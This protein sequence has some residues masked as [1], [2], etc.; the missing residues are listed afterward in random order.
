MVFPFL[1][2]YVGPALPTRFTPM[3]DQS[4]RQKCRNFIVVCLPI[5][6]FDSY[7]LQCTN[8]CVSPSS[9]HL[10]KRWC[11]NQNYGSLSKLARRNDSLTC[12]DLWWRAKKWKKAMG[13]IYWSSAS[14][15]RTPWWWVNGEV[16]VSNPGVRV[17][18]TNITV[19][20]DLFGRFF[21]CLEWSRYH[22]S[23]LKEFIN[24]DIFKI[25]KYIS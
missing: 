12:N 14:T 25:L 10:A 8:W 19:I 3:P 6:I 2:C 16:M 21:I 13:N 20:L 15:G 9:P 7:F 1:Y 4:G 5:V 22:Y 24:S 18:V 23:P 11:L 17:R